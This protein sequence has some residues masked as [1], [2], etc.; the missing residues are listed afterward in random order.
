MHVIRRDTCKPLVIIY[1]SA[2]GKTVRHSRQQPTASIQHRAALMA[3]LMSP[4]SGLYRRVMMLIAICSGR[5]TKS[6]GIYCITFYDSWCFQFYVKIT[7]LV[8]SKLCL[9]FYLKIFFKTERKQ[10]TVWFNLKWSY[11]EKSKA[12]NKGKLLLSR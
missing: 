10:Q 12:T 9:K 11:Q 3:D 4:P 6:F 8:S 5:P 7:S 1:K 2:L